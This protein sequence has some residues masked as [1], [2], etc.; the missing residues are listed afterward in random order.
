MTGLLHERELSRLSFVK[1][2]GGLVVGLS[3]LGGARVTR[4]E[5]AA[6]PF[7]SAGPFNEAQLDTW[8]VVHPDNTVSVLSGQAEIGQGSL[9]GIVQII[10]EE[11][12]LGIDQVKF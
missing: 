4:A 7:S 6:D 12:N 1:A 9:T 3:L 11:L 8:L 10:A 5:G 2:G